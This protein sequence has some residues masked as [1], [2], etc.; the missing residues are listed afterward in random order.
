MD[1]FD[2]L[3]TSHGPFVVFSKSGCKLCEMLGNDLQAMG[4]IFYEKKIDDDIALKEL[5]IKKTNHP[6]F[7]Q[8]FIGNTFI[9]GYSNFSKLCLTNSI[10]NIFKESNINYNYT[11]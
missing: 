8:I 4:V 3:L 5:L 1:T 6:T 10:Y 9:G 2:E 7:P 11:F